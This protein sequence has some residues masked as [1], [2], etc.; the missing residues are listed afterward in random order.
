MNI[1]NEF[2]RKIVFEY[3]EKKNAIER[4]RYFVVRFVFLYKKIRKPKIPHIPE[5]I[6]F[7]VM[8]RIS[9]SIIIPA[10]IPDAV[11]IWF[12]YCLTSSFN[13]F[14]YEESDN[15]DMENTGYYDYYREADIVQINFFGLHER[16]HSEGTSKEEMVRAYNKFLSEVEERAKERDVKFSIK[17]SAFSYE[18]A[19]N[20]EKFVEYHDIRN[21]EVLAV[22]SDYQHQADQY[23]AFFEAVNGRERIE[24]IIIGGFWWDD[25]MD[26]EVKVRISLS[27][28]PRNKPA[29]AVIKKWFN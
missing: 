29:E 25:A 6:I 21:P 14:A 19:V 27:P 17:F 8:L 1:K 2:I 3:D 22:K 10:V 23:Q 15:P 4:N 24:R 11:L 9:I 28:S 12:L 7:W 13:G 20:F 26:P 16:Y 5:I 18:N